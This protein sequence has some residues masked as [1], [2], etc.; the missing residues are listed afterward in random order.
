[1]YV[2]KHF[3]V[4]FKRVVF[5][6]RSLVYT[7]SKLNIIVEYTELHTIGITESWPTKI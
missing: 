3:E 5:N 2:C 6:A 4:G 1:M 7:K